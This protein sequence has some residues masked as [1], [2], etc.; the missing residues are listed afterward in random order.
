MKKL[1]IGGIVALAILFGIQAQTSKATT[2]LYGGQGGTGICATS[3]TN[4][5]Y[6]LYLLSITTSGAPVYGFQANGSGGTSTAA[7]IFFVNGLPFITSSSVNLQQGSNITITSSTN[8]SGIPTYTITGVAASGTVT[9][10]VG[11]SPIVVTQAGANATATCPTCITTTTGNWIGTWQGVNSST[12]Y[13]AT[14]PSAYISNISTTINTTGP[15]TGGGSF[16]NGTTLNLGCATCLTA[17]QNITVTATGE[18]T[19][20]GSGTT[21]ITVP[22]VLKNPVTENVSTTQVTTTALTVTGVKNALHLADGSGIVT[23]YAGSNCSG[24]QA[25]NGVTAVGAVSGCFTPAGGGVATT[26]PFTT[27][28]IPVISSTLA[29]ANSSIFQSTSTGNIGIFTTSPAS[30]LTVAQSSTGDEAEGLLIDGSLNGATSNADIELNAAS[31]SATEAN[32]DFTKGGVDYWQIGIQNNGTND[33]ELWDGL[34]NPAFTINNSTLDAAFGTSTASAELTI[35]NEAG[36][37]SP[38]LNVLNAS[39]TTQLNVSNNGDVSVGTSSDKGLLGV[40]NASGTVALALSTSTNV[41]SSFVSLNVKGN[42]SSTATI[43]PVSIFQILASGHINATGT[44]PN[45]GTC[46]SSPSVIGTDS[47]GTITV[48]SGVVTSCTMNF[49]IPYESSNLQC[50]ESDNSTA[51]TGDISSITTSSVTFSFSA[52]LGG[53]KLSYMCGENL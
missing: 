52:T 35:Q 15:L 29:L 7:T 3:S 49:Q 28:Y 32:V 27:G 6:N 25:V 14:N 26:S 23:A 40:V 51:V 48:G 5:G 37:V 47:M 10:I 41:T 38:T 1:I 8:G 24:G 19:G 9:Q 45:M 42:P 43:T 46:G 20:T 53:G 36:S 16:V 31:S 4:I 13:L 39:G 2:C 50:V 34:N 44:T 17:N 21:S 18:A 33:F 11:V 30:R 22:L 12:F